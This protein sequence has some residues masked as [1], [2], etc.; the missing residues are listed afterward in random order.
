VHV[1]HGPGTISGCQ[2]TY[3]GP[4]DHAIAEPLDLERGRGRQAAWVNAGDR[5]AGLLTTS[6]AKSA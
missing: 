5:D 6:M 2:D 3:D 1:G 4:L